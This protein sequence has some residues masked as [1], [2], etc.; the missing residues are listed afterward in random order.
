MGSKGFV[1]A[2][3]IKVNSQII[4]V[5]QA[6]RCKGDPIRNNQSTLIV[7]GSHLGMEGYIRI[8]M[9]GQPDYLRA[10]LER[11]ESELQAVLSLPV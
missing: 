10:G 11:V 2:E 8:W 4:N 3:K 9:G 5:D 7:P 1:G 6:M